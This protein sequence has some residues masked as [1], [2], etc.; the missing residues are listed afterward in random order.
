MRSIERSIKRGHGRE[1]RRRRR[2]RSIVINR[3]LKMWHE[4]A[5]IYSCHARVLQVNVLAFYR[6]LNESR[7]IEGGRVGGVD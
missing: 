6:K 5:L 7:G 1:T 3:W 2:R 4:I